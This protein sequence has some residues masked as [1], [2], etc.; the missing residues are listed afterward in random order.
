MNHLIPSNIVKLLLIVIAIAGT[1]WAEPTGEISWARIT[2][3]DSRIR[4]VAMLV[5]LKSR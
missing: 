5:T 3:D 1:V 2:E 4:I